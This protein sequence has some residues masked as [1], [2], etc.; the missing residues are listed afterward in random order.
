MM[1]ASCNSATNITGSAFPTHSPLSPQFTSLQSSQPTRTHFTDIPF[2]ALF[3]TGQFL[4]TEDFSKFA[5]T[6]KITYSVFREKIHGVVNKLWDNFKRTPHLPHIFKM[7]PDR[8]ITEDNCIQIYLEIIKI[9]RAIQ[10]S[11]A[12]PTKMT[13]AE[14]PIVSVK[15][16]PLPS[17]AENID[18]FFKKSLF[19][20]MDQ[21]ATQIKLSNS[22][23]FSPGPTIREIG[24]Q[25][26]KEI[27]FV[28][29]GPFLIEWK[30]DQKLVLLMKQLENNPTPENKDQVLKEI[31][32]LPNPEDKAYFLLI[33]A[34][35][36]PSQE[37]EDHVLKAI[38]DIDDPNYKVTPRFILARVYPTQ[39]N[40]DQALQT[41]LSV[42]DVYVKAKAFMLV[43]W[44]KWHPTPENC[45]VAVEAISKAISTILIQKTCDL[46]FLFLELLKIH[47]TPEISKAAREAF[48]GIRSPELALELLKMDPTPE[49]SEAARKIILD[50]KSPEF[51]LELLKMDPTPENNEVAKKI[52]LTL[53]NESERE[54]ESAKTKFLTEQAEILISKKEI[55]LALEAINDICMNSY[56]RDFLMK[57]LDLVW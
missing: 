54:R 32:A 55:P 40:R 36:Y 46:A 35:A 21:I 5:R 31:L 27:F 24:F 18:F 41:I 8:E 14:T 51:A 22:G 30:L 43:A 47:K 38:S 11:A 23:P 50:A 45:S 13:K 20:L 4:P 39:K 12:Q 25:V 28:M 33:F 42:S 44:T 17:N 1:T 15:K 34:R 19:L 37:N 53:S 48:I 56:R 26:K 52:F 9:C 49:N 16:D 6:S 57:V 3:N 2:L 7:L 29:D 10:A